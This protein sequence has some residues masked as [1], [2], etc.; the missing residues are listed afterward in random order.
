[1]VLNQRRV[2]TK[3]RLSR[4]CGSRPCDSSHWF[5]ILSEMLEENRRPLVDSLIIRS[6]ELTSGCVESSSWFLWYLLLTTVQSAF[7]LPGSRLH[8]LCHAIAAEISFK[9]IDPFMPIHLFIL[10]FLQC[11]ESKR[12]TSGMSLFHSSWDYLEWTLVGWNAGWESQSQQG[13]RRHFPN[14]NRGVLSISAGAERSA[15]IARNPS[16]EHFS[17]YWLGFAHGD[18]LP[19]VQ[20]TLSTS[21]K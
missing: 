20:N 5:D 12:W 2:E 11:S 1:M 13:Q 14:P 21:F 15:D 7:L 4:L 8:Q 6:V 9:V 16:L 18:C 19:A 17:P 10:W 3:E